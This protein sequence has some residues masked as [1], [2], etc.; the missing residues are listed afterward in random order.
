M[1]EL[2]PEWGWRREK[3]SWFQRQLRWSITEGAISYFYPRGASDARVIA[4]MACLCICVCPCVTRLYRI[5][6]AKCRIT[7]T[8]P[9][10]SPGTLVFWRQNSLVDDPP[11]TWNLRSKWPTPFQTAKF[12]P[13]GLFAHSASTVRASEKNVQL[14][15]CV[16]TS[17]GKVVATSFLYLGW[18]ARDFPIHQ[19]FAL[20]V[21]HP[22]RKRWFRQI[23]LNSAA[24]MR[25]SEKNSISTHR[26]STKR[27]P[28]SHIDVQCTSPVSPPKGGS[29]RE[30]VHLA[31]LFI[32]LLQVIVDI[33]NLICGLNIASPSLRMTNCPWKG[34]GHCHVTSLFFQK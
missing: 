14:A 4:I 31:L 8:T 33:S 3:G 28:A 29:K 34:R 16:K 22:F 2:V 13:I 32:S 11:S 9:C 5:K 18:I 10:D 7:Q 1:E 30:C 17:S 12:R 21:T 6:T 15:L 27:F 20:K 25:T 24:A 19:K 23:S 26:K